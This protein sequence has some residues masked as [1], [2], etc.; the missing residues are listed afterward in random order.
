MGIKDIKSTDFKALKTLE[1]QLAAHN[2]A[3]SEY[4][5]S[6][7]IEVLSE[8]AAGLNADIISVADETSFLSA[9]S[10]MICEMQ[11]SLMTEELTEDELKVIETE[12]SFIR[13]LINRIQNDERR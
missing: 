5:I 3:V 8:M 6:S 13:K 10:D 1:E 7:K 9:L 4:L 12:L 2:P 11:R